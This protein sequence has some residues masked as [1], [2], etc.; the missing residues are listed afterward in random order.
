MKVARTER[1]PIRAL[2]RLGYWSAFAAFATAAAYG[3]VQLLQLAVRR[4]VIT[5]QRL[6]LFDL[7]LDSFQLVLC[8]NRRFH[9]VLPAVQRG[10]PQ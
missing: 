4:L 9:L 5:G 2:A 10:C 8:L 3:V 7:L 1:A 6:Q